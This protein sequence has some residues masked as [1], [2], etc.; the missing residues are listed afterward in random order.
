MTNSKSRRTFIGR[1]TLASVGTMLFPTVAVCNTNLRKQANGIF[2]HKM[3]ISTPLFE[4]KTLCVQGRVFNKKGTVL[5]ANAFVEVLSPN[6]R[7]SL[8]KVMVSTEGHYQIK[9]NY[10]Q[11][12]KGKMAQ[13][14]LKVSSHEDSYETE[15]MVSDF[16]AF[17][18]NGH[19]ERNHLLGEKLFPR[20]IGDNTTH[21]ILFNLSI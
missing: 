15:L 7:H 14:N 12:E 2:F 9:V 1:V 21:K 10:P 16:D 13:L 6:K 18:S 11:R 3:D 20:K 17:I 5:N 4:T 8:G 19:W